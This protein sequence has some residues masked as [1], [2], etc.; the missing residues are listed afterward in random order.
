MSL[1]IAITIVDVFQFLRFLVIDKVALLISFVL[2]IAIMVVGWHCNVSVFAH[3]MTYS[4]GALISDACDSC[5]SFSELEHH[6]LFTRMLDRGLLIGNSY[7]TKKRG[8]L[9]G[10]LPQKLTGLK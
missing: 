4:T 5:E 7:S 1:F 6:A 10:L 2:I 8:N 3:E 9:P